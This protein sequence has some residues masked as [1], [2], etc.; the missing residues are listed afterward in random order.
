ML[1][2][3]WGQEEKGTTEDEMAEWHHWL[4]GHEFEWTP[5]VGNGQGG[6]ECCDSWCRKES[7]M[8]ERLNWTEGC[9]CLSLPESSLLC[10]SVSV[11]LHH[12]HCS[13]HPPWLL[14]LTV[15]SASP[16]AQ[17][18]FRSPSFPQDGHSRSWSTL[19][20]GF[21]PNIGKYNSKAPLQSLNCR[22]WEGHTVRFPELPCHI[23]C[24]CCRKGDPFQGPKLGS[25]LTLGNELSEEIHVLTK[26]GILLGKGT[27]WRG[28][29]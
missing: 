7:D 10:V 11:S 28:V 13:E 4:D 27:R 14:L 21:N 29:G 17:P 19:W 8:T 22:L 5:D 1:G 25:C 18:W 26:Q 20:K 3:I 23:L 15:R 6:L 12:K 2:G 9:E 16:P 24:P